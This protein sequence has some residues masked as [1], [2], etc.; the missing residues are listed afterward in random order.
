MTNTDVFR[1]FREKFP[2]TVNRSL[3]ETAA[4]GKARIM[5][6][7]AKG[8]TGITQA[9]W[10][11]RREGTWVR[12]IFNPLKYVKFL[13]SGTGLFGP[14]HKRITSR[15][16]GPLHWIALG[17]EM[18]FKGSGVFQ[19]KSR[20]G[21]KKGGFKETDRFYMSTAGM[22]AQPMIAPNIKIIQADL[23]KRMKLNIKNNWGK[24]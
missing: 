6:A 4:F 21:S 17:K 13:E 2:E 7:T 16:G 1:K 20:M 19:F 14:F 8:A 18:A 10:D 9:R 22:P 11:W 3:D 23:I 15:S 12:F 24:L 5:R